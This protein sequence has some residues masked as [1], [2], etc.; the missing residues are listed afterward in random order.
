MRRGGPPETRQ[1]R[2]ARRSRINCPGRRGRARLSDADSGS[3][4]TVAVPHT[5]GPQR[6]PYTSAR[7]P[8]RQPPASTK[9]IGYIGYTRNI[10]AQ[11]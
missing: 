4:H 5:S 10:T 6:I 9:V 3:D 1:H 2:R 11:R 8:P 7:R